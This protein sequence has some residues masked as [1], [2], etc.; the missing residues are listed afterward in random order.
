MQ[1]LCLRSS[2][3]LLKGLLTYWI[4]TQKVYRQN[5][6]LTKPYDKK[7][8]ILQ[9]TT[10]HKKLQQFTSHSLN[11]YLIFSESE[12]KRLKTVLKVKN[13]EASLLTGISA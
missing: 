11:Y 9:K 4:K 3:F 2:Y 13:F 6:G 12:P 5:Y 1:S 7:N 8:K 10:F